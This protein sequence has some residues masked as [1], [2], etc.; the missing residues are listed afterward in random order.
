MIK[1]IVTV[2]ILS[3]SMIECL[4]TN[5]ICYKGFECDGNDCILSNC[6]GL[7]K[8][9]CDKFKCTLD[10]FTCDEYQFVHDELISKKN[11]K[12]YR[13]YTE[14]LIKGIS[15]SSRRLK[16]LDLVLKQVKKCI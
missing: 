3:I 6:T 9:D 7:L 1:T 2:L 15:F 13:A 16:H 5:E 12:L 4:K 8:Y 10:A 14:A 11:S